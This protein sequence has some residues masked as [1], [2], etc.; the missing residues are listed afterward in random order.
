MSVKWAEAN[1]AKEEQA[2]HIER[3]AVS[4]EVR[5]ADHL[6]RRLASRIRVGRLVWI[7]LL[8]R[9]AIGR[10]PVDF[11]RRKVDEMLQLWETPRVFEQIEGGLNVILDE[12]DLS[13][14]R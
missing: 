6:S 12:G 8:V 7:R 9:L 5:L 10:G 2:A 13:H 3:D 4:V 11:V 14:A 1:G